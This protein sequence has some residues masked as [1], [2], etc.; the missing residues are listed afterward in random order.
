[1]ESGKTAVVIIII[2]MLITSGVGFFLNFDKQTV[3]RTEYTPIG[4][5]D[6]LMSANSDRTHESELYNSTYNVTNWKVYDSGTNQWIPNP[7]I[8]RLPSGQA[9][10]YIITDEY[11]VPN[12]TSIPFSVTGHGITLHTERFYN[13]HTSSSQINNY[14]GFVTTDN[15]LRYWPQN[16]SNLV[17]GTSVMDESGGAFIGGYGQLDHE[18]Y[19]VSGLNPYDIDRYTYLQFSYNDAL[20]S[21]TNG[22]TFS[23]HRH[24]L[25]NYGG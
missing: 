23:N 3:T 5:M 11:E 25:D 6:A 21:Y 7:D 8:V 20:Y 16:A 13:D 2:A 12:T 17:L 9:N 24:G 18:R 4:N 22:T 15:T 1:M 14:N 19:R 10:S